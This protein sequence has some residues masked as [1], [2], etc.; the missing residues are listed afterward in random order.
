MPLI[1][2]AY[3]E[4]EFLSRA[5]GLIGFIIYVG[6]FFCLCTGRLTSTTPAYFLLIL[7]ASSCV[8]VSLMAD[9]NLSAA[10]IQSFYIVMSTGG[11]AL[12][13]RSWHAFRGGG[14]SRHITKDKV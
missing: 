4:F 11:I 7:A 6:G 5:I 14:Q 10:L 3:F 1:D 9:F 2:P 12:R 13:W 8:M